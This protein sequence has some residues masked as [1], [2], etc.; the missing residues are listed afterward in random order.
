MKLPFASYVKA[1]HISRAA[2]CVGALVAAIVFFVLGAGIRLLIGPV[3]LGPLQSTLAGAIQEALPGITLKYDQAAIEWSRDE[4]RVNLV[5]L[6]ARVLDQDGRVVA[7]APKAD[8]DLAAAPFLKGEFVVRRI[9]LVGVQ[10]TLVHMKDG[11]VRL[12]SEG[13]KG[14]SDFLARL[15]DM[16]KVKG[17]TTS[18]LTSF[19]VRDAHIAIFDEISGLYVV[20]PRASLALTSKG[21]AIVASF[22]ADV[23]VSG[24]PA[25]IK[26]NFTLPPGNGPINGEAT[27]TRLDLRGLGAQAPMFADLRDIALSVNLAARFSI[28]SGGHILGTDFDLA[29]DGEVPFAALTGKVLHV[30]SLRLTG[31]YDGIRNHLSLSQADLN[32]KEAIARLKGSGDFHYDAQGK[33]QDIAAELSSGRV[34]LDMPG[35]LPQPV[36]LQ[37]V[38]LKAV[39]QAAARRFDIEKFSLT[40]P[41]LDLAAKGSVTLGEKGQSPG[42][43]ISGA[44]KP[45]ALRT[46]LRY[47]PL[48]AAAGAREWIDANIFAGSVGPLAFETHFT[49]GMMDQPFTPDEAITLSFAM[50]G[51]EGNY[52]SGLTHLTGV[53]GN[54]TMLGDSFTAD[55]DGGH[56][57]AI[58]VRGGH[59]VIPTLHVNGTVGV[60]TAHADGAM[61]DIMRLIDMKPLNYPTRFS[62]DPETTKGQAAVDLEFHVPMLADLPVDDVGISV[63]AAVSD[64]AVTLGRSTRLTNGAV[65]FDID[66]DHLH[67]TG[68]VNLADSRLTV[69]WTED[70][71][72]DAPITTHI[73]AKG[74]LTDA[75]RAAL[76]VGLKNILT[77][78]VAVNADIQG[79]RGHL[80]L[81]D[82]NLDLTAAEI[83]IPIL[84]LGKAAGMAQAGHVT[85]NFA[86]DDSDAVHDEIIRLTGPTVAATGTAQFDGTGALTV[87]NFP[88]VKMGALND[89]SVM[90]VS[91]ASGDDYTL[92]GRSLDGS[93][94]GRNG[95]TAPAGSAGAGAPADSMNGPFHINARLDRFAMRD[96]VSI[97]PFNLDLSGIGIRPGTLALSGSLS[98]TAPITAAIEATPAGRKLTLN[99]GDAGALLRGLFAFEGMRGGKLTMTA[100]LPGR[101]I[102]PDTAGNTPDFTGKLDIDDFTMLHQAFLT[103][104]FSAGSLTGLAD[105]MG[106]DGI[107]VANLDVPFASKN[108]VISVLGARVRGPAIGATADGYIDRPKGQLALKGSL[109]P[110]YMLNS[111]L[112]NIPLLGDILTS[113]KGEGI[114][115]VTYSATGNSEQPDINVNPLSALAP[116][117]FRRIFEGHMPTKADAPSNAPATPPATPPANAQSNAAIPLK[118]PVQ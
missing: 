43:A 36:G 37:A 66:N 79:H 62:I 90:R 117:I 97:A 54:A 86:A 30:R 69:D 12:G 82:A 2:L 92:R 51:I 87:L 39:W 61:T 83:A 103:R 1:H 27:I 75:A 115:A 42:V 81:L 91:T 20:A 40:A 88:S 58:A 110:A 52:I 105:L 44:L 56:I 84:N 17:S 7:V 9:T 68:A 78:P 65:N 93:M 71:R 32:A 59:A 108:N 23:T 118:P 63:K 77:G 18:S 50:S 28:A 53:S 67:Q 72:G 38:V 106:G 16:L 46:L 101:A 41:A 48:K 8:I 14:G 24:R 45:V 102:D 74:Q 6:G 49:P 55:F 107:S 57:G 116:G 94:I 64:F 35:V 111:L 19:A 80:R 25:H 10:L 60:F 47:W 73:S 21:E 70:F 31:A 11:S 96:G 76:N 114:F 85:V 104:L 33:L 112:S 34:A 15:N 4:G 98:K 89:L 113:K 109:I 99:A 13:D 5:V 26:T 29:A 100:V 3:S 95:A 22:D